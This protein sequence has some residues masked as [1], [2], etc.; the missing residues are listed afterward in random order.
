ML[1][2][3]IWTSAPFLTQEAQCKV[4]NQKGI[5]PCLP[6]SPQ[7]SFN[8]DQGSLIYGHLRLETVDK[9]SD[10]GWINQTDNLTWLGCK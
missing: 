6:I 5:R 7:S 10:N 1:S 9:T 4:R 8:T 3:D 2:D